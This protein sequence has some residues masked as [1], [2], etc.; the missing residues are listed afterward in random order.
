MLRAHPGMDGVISAHVEALIMCRKYDVALKAC[1]ASLVSRSLD[2]LYL[3]AEAQWRAG[4]PDEAMETLQAARLDENAACKCGSL[5][6]F[7]RQLLV[8][9][10]SCHADHTCASDASVSLQAA[11]A[12][13]DAA[14][15]KAS[16]ESA[17]AA[18]STVLAMAPVEGT[19]MQVRALRSSWNCLW[20]ASSPVSLRHGFSVG[21][22][23]RTRP[24]ATMPLRL[25]TSTQR[26]RSMPAT[27]M[28]CVSVQACTVR[29][30]IW[31]AASSMFVRHASWIHR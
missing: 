20:R 14:A 8:R 23:K 11:V 4:S 22:R 9:P 12:A 30:A 7:L 3:K 26:L 5:V 31:S 21:A 27:S 29:L 13:G 1:T 25:Q 6:A 2:A 17:V 19:H 24:C 28:R 18:Y 10:G 15:A 16:A